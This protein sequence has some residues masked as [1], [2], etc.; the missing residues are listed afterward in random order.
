MP[1]GFISDEEMNRL[2]QQG[3]A[4]DYQSTPGFISDDEMAR[5]EA[6]SSGIPAVTQPRNVVKETRA[7]SI[8]TTKRLGAIPKEQ[9][10][11]GQRET[12]TNARLTRVGNTLGDI[13]GGS[14]IGQG[15]GTRIANIQE[16]KD[17]KRV[18]EAP[19]LQEL[20]TRN[21]MAYNKIVSQGSGIEQ[22]PLPTRA[23]VAGDVA[24]IGANFVPVGKI[25]EG[26]KTAVQATP[27]VGKYIGAKTAQRAGNIL[28]AG[29]MGLAQD[30]SQQASEGDRLKPGAGTAISLAIC[31]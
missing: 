19:A 27:L 22:T 9:R 25:A 3:V 20:K 13:F 29:A 26:A 16:K 6:S 14:V 11:Q 12:L 4:T 7:G 31:C 24:R 30:F 18:M 17:A 5:L 23:Q 8:A 28:G 15:I 10:T 2:V 1:P 21:P